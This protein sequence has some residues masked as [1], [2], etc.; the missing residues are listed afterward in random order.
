MRQ[1]VLR[2]PKKQDRWFWIPDDDSLVVG[3]GA[4]ASSSGG[5]VRAPE[6]EAKPSLE[7]AAGTSRPP[8]I[9]RI[10]VDELASVCEGQVDVEPHHFHYSTGIMVP[11]GVDSEPFM[12]D[13]ILD[14][15][16]GFF[17]PS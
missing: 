6:A 1:R 10:G 9:S 4:A 13:T 15:G 8:F 14:S 17:F 12:V 3:V 11:G 7:G 2:G 16:A 5:I